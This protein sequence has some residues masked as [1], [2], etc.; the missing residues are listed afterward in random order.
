MESKDDHEPTFAML[1]VNKHK[2][3][4][5]DLHINGYLDPETTAT[6][7][8]VIQAFNHGPPPLKG[9]MTVNM[10][11][12]DVNDNSPVFNIRRYYLTA[13]ENAIM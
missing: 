11:V 3:L 8:L 2:V 6:Y 10:T 9:A 4:Y 1:A 7:H 13:S 12:M 5:L